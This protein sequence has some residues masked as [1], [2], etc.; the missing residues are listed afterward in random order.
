MLKATKRQ[1]GEIVGK[2]RV[3]GEREAWEYTVEAVAVNA[4]MAGARPEMFPAILALAASRTGGAFEFD[5]LDG[6]D[7]SLQWPN[8]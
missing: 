7:S 1:P 6:G 8:R 2:M 3:T 4:V 5:I